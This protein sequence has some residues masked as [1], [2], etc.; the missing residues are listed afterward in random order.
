MPS[1]VL[2]RPPSMSNALYVRWRDSIFVIVVAT[3]REMV[4]SHFISVAFDDVKFD[5]KK[6]FNMDEKSSSLVDEKLLSD[7]D[8]DDLNS[9]NK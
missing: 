1:E 2:L 9:W 4:S 6:L 7:F 3:R 5:T 8:R